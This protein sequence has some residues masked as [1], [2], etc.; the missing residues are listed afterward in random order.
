MEVMGPMPLARYMRMCLTSDSGGYYTRGEM[1]EGHD[2]F[3]LKGDFVTAPEISQVFG[4]LVGLW[5]VM[6]WMKQSGKP[7]D[8]IE[9]IETGPGRGTLMADM[10]RVCFAL[11]SVECDMSDMSGE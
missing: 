1:P 6:Q 8:T 3:G 5:F 10:L 9:I 4:E 2:Q 11:S 7:T